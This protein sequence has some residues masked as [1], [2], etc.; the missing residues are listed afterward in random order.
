MIVQSSYGQIKYENYTYS[1]DIKSVVLTV[2]EEIQHVPVL[3]LGEQDYLIVNFDD[4]SNTEED[5]R[6]KIIHCDRDWNKSQ[7]PEID[8]V[9]GYDDEL[10]RIWDFSQNTE[11]EYTHFFLQLP[12]RDTRFKISGNYIIYVYMDGD[13]GEVPLF[14]RRFIITENVER[15]KVENVR[16]SDASMDR[17]VQQYDISAII[18]PGISNPMYDV[19][20]E[21][22]QNGLWQY[23]NKTAMPFNYA[24]YELK[25]DPFGS[26]AFPGLAE[27]RSFDIRQINGGGRGVESMLIKYGEVNAYLY[28]EKLRNRTPYIFNFDFNGN[29]LLTAQQTL[30]NISG[31]IDKGSL[32]EIRREISFANKFLDNRGNINIGDLVGNYVKVHFTIESEK[33]DEDIYIFGAFTDGQLKPEFRMTYD[34]TE[35]V[36][37]GSTLLKQG[38]YDYMYAT[39]S[40][41]GINFGKTEGS[42]FDTE[43]EYMVLV[44]FREF[45]TRYD[46]LLTIK[47]FNSLDINTR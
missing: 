39:R 5:V 6:Y 41:Q 44:Y 40:K 37:R 2:N 21:V 15:V 31:V 35:G 19:T 30:R 46:R 32:A 3:M 13:D 10:I 23:S 9:E 36:Y 26:L 28:P 22:I 20:I 11:V 24:N 45:G 29:F 12:N 7:I 1:P 42:W 27:F 43:N 18:P 38:Y 16:A 4:L 34:E 33:I 8:Y 14:T 25:F 17:Y 47:R